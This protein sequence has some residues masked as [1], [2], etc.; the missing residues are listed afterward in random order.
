LAL[1]VLPACTTPAEGTNGATGKIPLAVTSFSTGGDTVYHMRPAKVER[2]GA[3]H[4]ISAAFH[5]SVSCR[6]SD[7]K[8]RWKAGTGGN[9]PFDLCVADIDGDGLDE[10]LVAE[11]DGVLYAIGPDGRQ[12]WS[13]NQVAPLY[14]ACAARQLDGKCIILTGGIDQTLYALTAKGKL[15]GQMPVRI[16]IRHLRAADILG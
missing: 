12:L 1:A 2:K 3:P 11:G 14:Q 9:F 8:L 16:S 6:T 13:F 7:G 4:L 10:V 15:R 5:G